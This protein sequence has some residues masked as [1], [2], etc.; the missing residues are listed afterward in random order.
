MAYTSLAVELASFSY[1]PPGQPTPSS[2]QLAHYKHI[3]AHWSTRYADTL[4]TYAAYGLG[5]EI[6]QLQL[7]HAGGGREGG[8]WGLVPG[9]DFPSLF[10]LAWATAT[11]LSPG[12][13]LSLPLPLP[14]TA[15]LN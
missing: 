15:R 5:L 3:G 12:G 6:G 1:R 7:M 2:S 8:G 11:Y 14:S 4:T 13:A 9:E 10:R